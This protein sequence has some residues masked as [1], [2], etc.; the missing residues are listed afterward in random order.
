MVFLD[1]FSEYYSFSVVINS[2][3]I[4]TK[5]VAQLRIAKRVDEVWA[6]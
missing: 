5:P 6:D 4:L 1:P 2:E 3:V